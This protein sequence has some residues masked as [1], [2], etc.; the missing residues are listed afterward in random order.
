MKN[1]DAEAANTI[2]LGGISARR[3]QPE[4]ARAQQSEDRLRRNGGHKAALM[5][6][7]VRIPFLGNPVAD[8]GKPRGAK[9]D[10]HMG[11]DGQVGCS[12]RS[13]R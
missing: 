7:P 12:S 6:E 1:E 8:K 4:I 5:V 3:G 2:N 10:H 9:R 11:I 13:E